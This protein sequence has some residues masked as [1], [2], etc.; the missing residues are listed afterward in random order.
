M[1]CLNCLA[2]EPVASFWSTSIPIHT[3]MQTTMCILLKLANCRSFIAL[4]FVVILITFLS[5]LSSQS[6]GMRS[7]PM[8]IDAKDGL[9]VVACI[10]DVSVYSLD[11][12][13]HYSLL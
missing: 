1:F 8:G 11:G 5:V 3:Y 6:V 12:R 4:N 2:Q 9:T 7:Q 13:L 10:N